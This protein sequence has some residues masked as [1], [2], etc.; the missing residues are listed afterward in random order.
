MCSNLT[1]PNTG[2][3]GSLH[4]FLVDHGL[5]GVLFTLLY[6]FLPLAKSEERANGFLSFLRFLEAEILLMTPS[7]RR[8]W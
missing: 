6:L 4:N 3:L 2:I 8:R 7:K 1:Q 5:H